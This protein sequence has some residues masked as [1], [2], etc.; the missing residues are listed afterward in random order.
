MIYKQKQL[1][2]RMLNNLYEYYTIFDTPMK[3]WEHILFVIG[4]GYDFIDGEIVY[5]GQ[6]LYSKQINKES[7]IKKLLKEIEDYEKWKEMKPEYTSDINLKIEWNNKDIEYIKNTSI[8]LEKDWY[9]VD[10]FYNDI[11]KHY[12]KNKKYYD[13]TKERYRPY[14]S[15]VYSLIFKIDNSYHDKFVV[16]IAKNLVLAFIKYLQEEIAARN[17]GDKVSWSN[18]KPTIELLNLLENWY[19][20]VK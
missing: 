5:N 20:S 19:K 6:S 4:N 18:E 11:Q 3:Y 15:A 1:E 17:F 12:K 8:N 13:L 10:S 2:N 14:I 7:I 9:S 16:E